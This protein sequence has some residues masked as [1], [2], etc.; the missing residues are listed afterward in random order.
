[1]TAPAARIIGIVSRSFAFL[2]L[3]VVAIGCIVPILW[4]LLA[5]SKTD[6]QIVGGSPLAFGTFGGYRSAWQNLIQFQD[7]VLYHWMTN[8]LVYSGLTV[9]LA[10]TTATLAGYGLASM[11][12]QARRPLLYAT[13]VSMI[14]PAAA[15][16]LP[17]FLEISSFGLLDTGASVILPG[18]FYPFGVYLAFLHFST[19]LPREI[20]EAARIDGASE[21]QVFRMIVLPLSKAM[22]GLL[23]FFAFVSNWTSFFLP[24]VMLTSD[25]HFTLPLGLNALMANT[26]AL[27]PAAGGSFL[28]IHRPEVALAGLLTVLPVVVV[29]LVSQRFLA[30]GILTGAVKS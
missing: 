29:F 27:N 12:L 22:V 23:T 26:P 6:A 18:A 16:V 9:L 2:L 10:V 13:L 3:V 5:P 25:D 24:F 20:I 19:A 21:A 17:L 15:M 11:S 8:S 1:M 28:P 30:R 4:L 7:G 14:L